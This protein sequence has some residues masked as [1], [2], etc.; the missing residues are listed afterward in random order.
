MSEVE[1]VKDYYVEAAKVDNEGYTGHDEDGYGA[2]I[3][4]PYMLKYHRRWRRVFAMC[5]SN[6]SSHYIKEGSKKLFLTPKAE[7]MIE[8]ARDERH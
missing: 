5:F 6:A 2:N 8:E 7:A 3:K 1:Y 4:S